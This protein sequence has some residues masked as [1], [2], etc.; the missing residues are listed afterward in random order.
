MKNIVISLNRNDLIQT[1]WRYYELLINILYIIQVQLAEV[2]V[3]FVVN[4]E[5]FQQFVCHFQERW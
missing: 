1:L 4:Q 5:E 3:L 2:I